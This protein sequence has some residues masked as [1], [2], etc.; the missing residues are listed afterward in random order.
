MTT[1]SG[2]RIN[3]VTIGQVEFAAVRALRPHGF[4][5]HSSR[6]KVQRQPRHKGCAPNLA[7][8]G[9][10]ARPMLTVT[11]RTPS[12]TY[13]SFLFISTLTRR[14]RLF[15]LAHLAK[16]PGLVL[17]ACD[18]ASFSYRLGRLTDNRHAQIVS[19]LPISLKINRADV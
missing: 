15:Y 10:A 3:D 13:Q 12:I 17:R 16:L 11:F 9:Q 5:L 7:C 6:H 18:H 1:P 8:A 19:L 4:A 2:N 14:R